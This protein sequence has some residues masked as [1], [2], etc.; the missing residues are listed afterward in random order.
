[1]SLCKAAFVL[2]YL[3]SIH[4]TS[5]LIT[6]IT[7]VIYPVTDF[8][9]FNAVPIVTCKIVGSTSCFWGTAKMLQLIGLI[10]TVIVPITE[11]SFVDAAAILTGKLVLLARLIGAS[12]LITAIPTI[13]SAVTP[14]KGP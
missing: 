3:G 14:G 9:H 7:A 1:M 4:T 11:V 2:I 5:L 13:I 8:D 6:I 12:P 10:P